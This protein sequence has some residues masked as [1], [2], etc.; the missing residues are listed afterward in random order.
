MSVGVSHKVEPEV[1]SKVEVDV[2]T[3]IQSKIEL[4]VESNVVLWSHCSAIQQ[5][6]RSSKLS[7]IPA[8]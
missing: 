8:D 5:I 6:S 1:K 3:E 7:I 4:E 2:E